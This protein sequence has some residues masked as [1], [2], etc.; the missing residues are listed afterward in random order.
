M[1]VMRGAGAFLAFAVVCAAAEVGPVVPQTCQPGGFTL[2]QFTGSVVVRPKP[3]PSFNVN[4]DNSA[5]QG[6]AFD[7]ALRS[8]MST[9]SSVG[10]SAWRYNFSGYTAAAASTSD[11]QMTVVNG[12]GRSFP[13]GVLATTMIRGTGD[14]TI[15]DSDIFFNPAY[16]LTTTGSGLDFESVALHEMGHGLGLDHNDGCYATRTVMQ[17]GLVSGTQK[18]SLAPPEIDGLRYLY[19]NSGTAPPTTP[20]PIIPPP[21]VLTAAPATLVFTGLAGGPVPASQNLLLSGAAGLTWTATSF[22]SWLQLA[23]STGAVPGVVSVQALT[24][25]LPAG[26][27]SGRIT[28]LS[29]GPSREVIVSLNLSAPN[30][31]QLNPSVLSFSALA[32]DAPASQSLLL[33]GTAGLSFAASVVTGAPWLRISAASG[34]L[35]ASTTIS[36]IPAAL[37]PDL[38]AGRISVTA[39]GITREVAVQFSVSAQPR[40]EMTPAQL[41]FSSP[42][43]STVPLCSSLGLAA[44]SVAG[45]FAASPAAPW[46]SVLPASGRLPATLTVCAA[47][48]SLL[49]E[50]TTPPSPSLPSAPRR[51]F[52]S[53]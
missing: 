52:R 13:S 31:L 25:D 48:G 41:S 29:A 32:G 10:G 36:V 30:S 24:A 2:L 39:A 1:K 43:G 23:P 17:S 3:D 49:A 5:Y 22:A 38:Y 45:D 19:S 20:P 11:G 40:P 28:I 7:A 35:P 34:R 47:A 14:G 16:N 21:V 8:A 12:G 15:Y 44:G 27:H 18:R 53:V 51:P 50:P 42:A 6:N 33:S 46:L 9:W 37:T 26:I 4:L